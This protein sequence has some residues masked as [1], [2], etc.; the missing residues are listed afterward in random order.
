MI[1]IANLKR[2]KSCI[3]LDR[4]SILG[5]P[6]WMQDESQRGAVI[7]AYRRWLWNMMEGVDRTYRIAEIFGVKVSTTYKRPTTD[8]V[9]EALLNLCIQYKK[10]G[11]LTIGCWCKPKD[12]HLDVVASAIQYYSSMLITH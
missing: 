7:E 5:N 11:V 12:C 8:Q 3:P 1:T 2:T 6:F 4:T 9:K 10:E